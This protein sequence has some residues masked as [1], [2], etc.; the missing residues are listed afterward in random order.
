MGP[1]DF[2]N[3]LFYSGISISPLVLCS[4]F[5]VTVK[6]GF[7]IYYPHVIATLYLIPLERQVV[8]QCSLQQARTSSGIFLKVLSTPVVENL[9]LHFARQNVNYLFAQVFNSITYISKNLQ[10]PKNALKYIN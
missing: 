3:H 8:D 10:S 9:F 2:P 7:V 6:F 4:F 1:P 5:A